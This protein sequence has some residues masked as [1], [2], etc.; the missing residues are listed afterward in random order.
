MLS[1]LTRTKYPCSLTHKVTFLN[2]LMC[3]QMPKVIWEMYVKTLAAIS[4]CIVLVG[5]KATQ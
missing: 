4:S 5:S 3:F 2:V 1:K